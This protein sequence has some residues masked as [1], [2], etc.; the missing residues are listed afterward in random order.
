MYMCMYIYIYI[1]IYACIC[2]IS[3]SIHVYI[4]IYIHIYVIANRYS[5]E[6]AHRLLTVGEVVYLPQLM[7]IHMHQ[8]FRVLYTL[9]KSDTVNIYWW[10][11]IDSCRVLCTLRTP[12]PRLAL[13]VAGCKHVYIYI[14]MLYNVNS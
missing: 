3:L 7:F 14:Y 9:F 12:V 10:W 1:H 8:S 2:N 11:C 4:Y 5:R 13:C 6:T